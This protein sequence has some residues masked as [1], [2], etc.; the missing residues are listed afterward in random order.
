[1]FILLLCFQRPGFGVLLGHF[2]FGVFGA[3]ERLYWGDLRP[4]PFF[5]VLDIDGSLFH[6]INVGMSGVGLRV[7]GTL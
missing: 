4:V 1:M 3:L 7:F 2:V 5:G 6:W